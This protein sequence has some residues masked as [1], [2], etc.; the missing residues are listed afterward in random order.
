[1]ILVDT[2]VWVD[3]FNGRPTVETDRLEDLLGTEPLAI[4]DLILTEVLQGF[5]LD[6][7][8]RTAR[9]LLLSLTVFELL[10]V[11]RAILSAEYFRQLRKRGITVRKTVDVAIAT[12]CISEDHA[13]LYSD[14]DFDPFVDH[15]G[16]TSAL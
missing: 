16:L 7:D 14:R 13:L 9:D 15:L 3:F 12:F 10:G 8:F 2:S 6:R 1:M 4:G 5:R 11:D